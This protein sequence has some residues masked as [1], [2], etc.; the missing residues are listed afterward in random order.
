MSDED[1]TPVNSTNRLSAPKGKTPKPSFTQTGDWVWMQQALSD[2]GFRY[3]A[4]VRAF[5]FDN[6]DEY[7]VELTDEVIAR[8]LGK[9]AKSVSAA[10][11]DCYA[12]GVIEELHTW[13]ESVRI[14]GKAR[15]EVRTFRRLIVHHEVPEGWTG[16]VNAYAE[17]R[18]IEQRRSAEMNAKRAERQRA[19][20]QAGET[21]GHTDGKV[22]S[23]HTDQGEPA[24][25]AGTPAT[26][27]EGETPGQCEGKIS[28]RT[29]KISSESGKKSSE[30]G[31]VSSSTTTSDQGKQVPYLPYHLP[32]HLPIHQD[33]GERGDAQDV[34]GQPSGD[35]WM[36]GEGASNEEA[37]E[38][39]LLLARVER[40][41]GG[42]VQA[43]RSEHIATIDA[44]LSV[45][46]AHRVES[47]LGD[48]VRD[49]RNPGGVVV[50]RIAQLPE[51]AAARRSEMDRAA[52]QRERAQKR[53]AD[54][55]RAATGRMDTVRCDHPKTESE[56]RTVDLSGRG[57]EPSELDPAAWEG[58]D[59]KFWPK[60]LR[61]R[62]A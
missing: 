19:R 46:P 20:E 27:S 38:G 18:R 11:R 54:A 42:Y 33:A 25:A 48:N 32:I 56:S 44:A 43:G 23:G 36:D 34:T 12:A 24:P 14:E 50:T 29:G 35:G 2:R 59:R 6:D 5:I 3:Y 15:P 41:V 9:T 52:E 49:T 40:S 62:I 39:A 10:R 22:S 61:E 28:S 7:E 51:L 57:V 53:R 16:P 47:H 45:L 21:P 1:T 8:L 58:V 37:S 26:P 31:K 13:K 30:T 17:K 55:D 4:A 60:S